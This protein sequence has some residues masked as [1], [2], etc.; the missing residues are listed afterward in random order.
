M[1]RKVHNA[2]HIELQGESLRKKQRVI[3]KEKYRLSLNHDNG[4]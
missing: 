2:H 1:D 3:Y 4:Q